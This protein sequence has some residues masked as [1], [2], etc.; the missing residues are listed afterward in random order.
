L[1][2]ISSTFISRI[3]AGSIAP[4]VGVLALQGDFAEH[5]SHLALVGVESQLVRTPDELIGCD[6]LI[7]PGGESTT[8]SRLLLTSGVG[9]VLK[10]RVSDGLLLFGTCAGM[11]LLASKVVDGRDDQLR[12]GLIDITVRRNGFGR[13]IRSFEADVD[14]EGV[15]GVPMRAVFIRAPVVE[16]VDSSVSVLGEVTYDF[17]SEGC[18]SVPVV[19]RNSQVLVCSFHPELTRDVRLHEYFVEMIESA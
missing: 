1:R 15:E 7:L 18:T 4:R 5:L 19:C 14:V 11:I 8:I 16:S 17:G 12:L 13:Q 10:D 9:S 3:G 6:G 2:W